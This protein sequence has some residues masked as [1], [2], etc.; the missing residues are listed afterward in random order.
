[1]DILKVNYTIMYIAYK[2]NENVQSRLHTNMIGIASVGEV[3]LLVF[4][5]RYHSE[6]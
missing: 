3:S 4:L 2:K 6:R 5:N 1:M